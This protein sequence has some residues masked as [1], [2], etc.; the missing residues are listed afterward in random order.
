MMYTSH[1]PRHLGTLPATTSPPCSLTCLALRHLLPLPVRHFAYL[2]RFGGQW[3]LMLS[4][5]SGVREVCRLLFY[6]VLAA[7]LFVAVVPRL[8]RRS[9]STPLLPWRSSPWC[10][11]LFVVV[12]PRLVRRSS[13]T[14][15]QPVRSSPL[16]ALGSPVQLRPPAHCSRL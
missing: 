9:S 15:L 3:C 8:V 2:H 12:V 13:S 16:A 4:F 5:L 14:P 11:H 6:L 10:A 1:P 7:H